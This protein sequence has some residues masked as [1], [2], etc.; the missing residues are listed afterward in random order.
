MSAF[1]TILYSL[2]KIQFFCQINLQNKHFS[3]LFLHLNNYVNPQNRRNAEK[4]V[5]EMASN[6]S[7]K[8]LNIECTIFK[9][10]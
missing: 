1:K 8:W 7:K 4:L 9:T 2:K 5:E 3:F 10:F 6:K